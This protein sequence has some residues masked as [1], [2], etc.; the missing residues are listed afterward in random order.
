MHPP[1]LL[2]T[3]DPGCGKTTAVVAVVKRLRDAV[4]M[5][6]FVTEEILENGRR[7]GF[8]G[9]TLDGRSFVLADRQ[10]KSP[11][12][13][14][15]YGIDVEALESVGVPAL[16]PDPGTGLIVLDEVGKME[17]FS[18]LFRC[19]VRELLDGDTPLLATVAAHGVGFVKR[20]RQHP[21][22]E[23]I[24]MRREARG[25]MPGEI[26]RRLAAR[27]ISISTACE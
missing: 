17:C 25:A 9:R 1:K 19:R 26:L 8:R 18:E 24:R 15:P 6:G 14:G 20:V 13:V 27:G 2:L 22:V 23:L 10:L 21:A 4:P 5:R 11:V 7:R 12:T 3:G 16:Q